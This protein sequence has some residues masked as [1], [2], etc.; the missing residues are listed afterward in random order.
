[1]ND[2]GVPCSYSSPCLSVLCDFLANFGV[3]R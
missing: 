1:M 2:T 3:D